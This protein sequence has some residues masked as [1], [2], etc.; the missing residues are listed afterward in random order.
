MAQ[1]PEEETDATPPVRLT[2]Y[3]DLHGC[4]CK[5]GQSDLEGLLA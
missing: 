5:L 4:S 2:E 1:T 3:A